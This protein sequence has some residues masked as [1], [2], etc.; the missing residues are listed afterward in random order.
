MMSP[1]TLRN[2]PILAVLAAP[3]HRDFEALTN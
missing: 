2:A 1:T 3:S